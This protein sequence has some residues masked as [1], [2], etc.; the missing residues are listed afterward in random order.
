[1]ARIGMTDDR[2]HILE[3]EC[4]RC[5]CIE[6]RPAAS[7]PDGPG[8]ALGAIALDLACTDCGHRSCIAS[9]S[10]CTGEDT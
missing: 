4:I 9:P 7:L 10:P 3:I 2:F 8:R 6:Y 5:G 1:M